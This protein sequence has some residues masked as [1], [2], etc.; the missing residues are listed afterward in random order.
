[1]KCKKVFYIFLILSFFANTLF[2]NIPKQIK[3]EKVSLQLKWKYQ[4]QF[5][6]FIVAKEKGFYADE[7]LDVELL[8]F[9]NS[10]NIKDVI[11]KKSI[12]FGVGDSS[13]VYESMLDIPIV[14]MMAIFQESAYVLMGLESSSLKNIKDLN[15]KKIALYNNINSVSIDA[16]LKSNNINYISKPHVYNL[17]KLISG[18]VDLVSS[19]ISNEPFIAKEMG[20]KTIL[21]D[22]KDY[23]FDGYGDILFT[24]KEMLKNNPKTVKKMYKAS[25][26]GWEYAFTHIDE[27][28]NLIYKKYNTLAKSKE[29]LRYEA[30]V[31]K[32][33]SGYG[34]NFG[35]LSKEKIKR[36]ANITSFMI[37]GNYNLNNLDDFIY[38]PK[39]LNLSLK[40]KK[41]LKNKKELSVC[42]NKSW[43]PYESFSDGK[44]QGL[45]ADIVNIITE[46]LSLKPKFLVAKNQPEMYKM[47]K[48]KQCDIKT[49]FP[50]NGIKI[51]PY[52]GTNSFIND[53]IAIVTRIEQ[54]YIKDLH[55]LHNKKVLIGKGFKRF[56]KYIKQ[57]YP[58]LTL[59]VVDDIE[60]ALELVSREKVFG[61][62]GTTFN[63]SYWIQKRFSSKL[64]IVNDFEN[65]G[66]G[67][68]VVNSEHIL[69]EILNKVIESTLKDNN[70]K[71]ID[72]WISTTVEK[73]PDFTFWYKIVTI[74]ILILLIVVYFLIKQKRL[75]KE[76]RFLNK[77][78]EKKVASQ[79]QEIIKSNYLLLQQSRLAQM[80]EMIS[81]IAHQW[82]QPLGAIGSAIVGMK[83][84]L[85]ENKIN[86][87]N[88]DELEQYLISVDKKYDDIE[89]YTNF[90]SETIT[91]FRNFYKQDKDKELISLTDIIEKSLSIIEASINT[92][93]IKIVKNYNVDKELLVYKN[94]IIQVII[95][96]IKNAEDN[97]KDSLVKNT[98]LVAPE[99]ILQT[100]KEKYN[101][102]ISIC[103]NG[104]GISEEI[105]E[106]IFDP[107]FSTKDE[108]NGTGLG[109]YMSK[110]MIEDRNG[111]DLKVRN[112]PN[113][114][115]FE[116]VLRHLS[117]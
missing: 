82:R 88:Q 83:F 102:I 41:Y 24:S 4:F 57:N 94:E 84:Q 36:I 14:A 113:G 79:V 19:Y 11:D 87:K 108:K 5:A 107:Y 81:M 111:G 18:E 72:K 116:I 51:V 97:F 58:E 53:S 37:S 70:K 55:N 61:Y 3:L 7:G 63:S 23:T 44:Y 20:L 34:V 8:E 32:S 56:I 54:P 109:L 96:I 112:I 59:E 104:G 92:R 40:E 17:D 39:H 48:S 80:G 77:N 110:I 42:I 26:K 27:V 93:N 101:Y 13:L 49:I 91:D 98:N 95:N 46:E 115:C 68:G 106:K 33:I 117:K 64:K 78:L 69:L 10:K 6:G 15:G 86:F 89:K 28:V 30:N 43:L 25:K 29:A 85:K 47:L 62:I 65:I 9:D 50:K 45:G 105:L 66:F 38:K 52:K 71:I 31:L 75:E 35:E 90:L 60:L 16:M 114:V 12:H 2:A 99:I 21:F 67:I 103:D 74:F 1:M 73:E 100:R 76:L 22:P